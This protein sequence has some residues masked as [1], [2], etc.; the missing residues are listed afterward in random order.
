MIFQVS[1]SDTKFCK[2]IDEDCLGNDDLMITALSSKFWDYI[3]SPVCLQLPDKT[4]W[5]LDWKQHDDTHVLFNKW[6]AFAEPHIYPINI[7][8]LSIFDETDTEIEYPMLSSLFSPWETKTTKPAVSLYHLNRMKKTNQQ[9]EPKGYLSL[10]AEICGQSPSQMTMPVE[11]AD[12][13]TANPKKR[14]RRREVPYN[15]RG[16]S[17]MKQRKVLGTGAL[18]RAKACCSHIK[19]FIRQ[20]RP[21]H[22]QRNVLVIPRNFLTTRQQ[23]ESAMFWIVEAKRFCDGWKNFVTD[24]KLKQG[25]VCV[26]QLVEAPRLFFEVVI[27]RAREQSTPPHIQGTFDLLQSNLQFLMHTYILA[28]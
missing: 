27:F 16:S 11:Y 9:E 23:Q 2:I 1:E 21:S 12:F 6:K 28:P 13:Y 24:N 22:I 20:M 3:S 5:L 26:F 15:T 4:T 7:F 8:N 14:G 19:S 10:L 18:E 17:T 25:D